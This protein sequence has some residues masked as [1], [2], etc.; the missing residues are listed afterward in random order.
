MSLFT[1]TIV[2]SVV[3]F[4]AV[5]NFAGRRVKNLDDYLV[6][7]RRAPTLLIVGTLVASLMSTT[8]FMGEAGFTYAGQLGPYLLLPGLTVTGY[9]Y[10]ALFFGTYLRRSQATT[11]AAFFGERFD[12]GGVQR[13]AGLTIILGLGGYLLVVTQGAALLI[14]ELTPLNYVQG[15]FVAWLGYSAFTLYAGSR[16]VILTDTL[17]FLLFTGA[18]LFF[19]AHL[20]ESFGGISQAV[21]DLT[22]QDAK[23]GLT[24]WHGIIGPGTG[25][26]TAL[27]FL[28]WFLVIDLSWSL[29]YAVSPWQSSRHLMAKS[30]HVV[31][32][33]AI[34][35]CVVVIFLQILIYGVGGVI[36]LANPAIEPPETVLIWAATQLVPPVLGAL[37]VAGIIAAALSSASTFLSLVGFS[38][39]QDLRPG[40]GAGGLRMTRLAMAGVSVVVLGLSLVIPPNVFWI[41]LFIG[42][43]FASSWGPVG[44]LSIWNR[45]ITAR[46][47]RWGMLAGLLGNVVPAGLDYVGVV[48]LPSYLEPALLGILASLIGVWAGSRGQSPSPRQQRYRERLHQTPEQDISARATRI[49]LIAPALLVGYGLTMPWLLL[50]YYVRPYQVGTGLLT[51]AGHINWQYAEPWFALGPAV[52]LV[53][54]GLLAWVVIGRRYSP[55]KT[56]PTT[57]SNRT[58][59]DKTS[60]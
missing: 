36:N 59:A 27:D 24:A 48:D 49:T 53:P 17:M 21:E 46:G 26:P 11:V 5:G 42:T 22:R 50:H 58:G 47:A 10:G 52:L 6:A 34:Y 60:T 1:L 30:E 3:L 8:V 35:A 28:I 18:T 20:L 43:V 12:D 56:L 25:W 39:S 7:G 38:V 16:G 14:A 2:A 29:V 33:A 15:I 45:G 23:P 13:L 57:A 41:T 9:V 32:R 51:S 44:L 31:L 4:I 40:K 37:L 54:L 19:T 55:G